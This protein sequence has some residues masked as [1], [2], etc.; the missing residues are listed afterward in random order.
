MS[1]MV[2]V[3]AALGTEQPDQTLR[4]VGRTVS[5]KAPRRVWAEQ[6]PVVTRW[7]RSQWWSALAARRRSL[8]YK[9][10]GLAAK[11]LRVQRNATQRYA[12]GTPDCRS[13]VRSH[14]R[15]AQAQV[16]WQRCSKWDGLVFADHCGT[17]ID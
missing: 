14:S 8:S 10:N 17:E 16:A 12:K 1:A 11:E 15:R 13:V 4:R 9:C 5:R 7:E 2:A 3:A 6:L